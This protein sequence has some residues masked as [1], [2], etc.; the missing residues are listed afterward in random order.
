M[1]QTVE[2]YWW[3]TDN[4]TTLCSPG[5]FAAVQDWDADVQARCYYDTLVAYNKI[6]PAASVSGRYSNG[7]QFACLTSGK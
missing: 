4:L 3:E 5:C 6:V 1:A 7:V 2:N